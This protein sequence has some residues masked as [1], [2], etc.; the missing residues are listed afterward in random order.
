[1]GERHSG[2]SEGVDVVPLSLAL[3]C[4][5]GSIDLLKLD[6]EGA[7]YV[8]LMKAPAEILEHIAR[9][10]LEYHD[11]AAIGRPLELAAPLGSVLANRVVNKGR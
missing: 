7:E 8:I 11:P 10:V 3:E 9:I 4:A 6:C 2:S 1:M 5:G